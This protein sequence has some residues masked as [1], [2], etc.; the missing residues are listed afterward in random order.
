MDED[1]RRTIES[2]IA[3]IQL[4][5]SQPLAPILVDPQSK[6]TMDAM[7]DETR[8]RLEEEIVELQAQHEEALKKIFS[9]KKER[10]REL[11]RI[12]TAIRT[13]KSKITHLG[14]ATE[15]RRELHQQI[16]KQRA[17]E[18]NTRNHAHRDLD[19]LASSVSHIA[20]AAAKQAR[21]GGT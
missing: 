2:G 11:T 14:R 10:R 17:M 19:S 1:E 18:E 12:E 4:N 3:Q 15:L 7:D 16:R 20:V 9:S 8:R 6:A 21:A 13:R 5:S